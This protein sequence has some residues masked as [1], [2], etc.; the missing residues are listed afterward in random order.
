MLVFQLLIRGSRRTMPVAAILTALALTASAEEPADN[1]PADNRSEIERGEYLARHVAMCVICHSPRDRDGSPIV[2]RLFHGAP[3]PV[4]GPSGS[5][6]W[7]LRAPRIAGLPGWSEDEAVQLLS[8]GK[9]SRGWSPRGPMPPY[10][11]READARAIVRYLKA[12][13]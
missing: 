4:E 5:Q 10:R 7:S 13:R 12:L 11:L 2:S 8:E 6:D 3:I 9:D 1:E